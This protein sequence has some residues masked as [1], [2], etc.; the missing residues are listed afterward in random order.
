MVVL[1]AANRML[2]L[3][4]K[5]L[6]VLHSVTMNKAPQDIASSEAGEIAVAYYKEIQVY[7]IK[8][9]SI[10]KETRIIYTREPITSMATLNDNL[11]IL[12]VK[13]IA[14]SA[15]D[16]DDPDETSDGEYEIIVQIRTF[17]N[18]ILVDKD[19]FV[20][21]N[22]HTVN[23]SK[24]HSISIRKNEDIIILENRQFK[25]F[26][27]DGRLKWFYKFGLQHLSSMTFDTE[28]NIYICD[29]SAK[30]IRQVEANHFMKNRVIAS[31]AMC[32]TS[33]L[34]IPNEKTIIVGFEDSVSMYV[35]KFI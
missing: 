22:G 34:F 10:A 23:F 8:S 5:D 30:K 18:K 6:K 11:A 13:R 12:F 17:K 28:G 15:G 33:I 7:Q 26:G 19:S 9:T 21:A 2:K 1:D 16:S 27:M 3:V 25:V 24:P 14:C 32:P 4:G 20:D 29:R 31:L 35:Y